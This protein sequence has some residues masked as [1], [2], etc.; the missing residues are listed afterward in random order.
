MSTPA[1]AAVETLNAIPIICTS[2]LRS[3]PNASRYITSGTAKVPVTPV[4]RPFATPT[5]GVANRSAPAGTVNRARAS[6][7]PA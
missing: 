4:T 6:P 2:W 1:R 5:I 3:R 7:V